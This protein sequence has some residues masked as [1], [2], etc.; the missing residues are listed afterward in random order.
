MLV[1]LIEL[2]TKPNQSTE[3][4]RLFENWALPIARR[5]PGYREGMCLTL[6]PE[7]R[8]LM[9]FTSWHSDQ[10]ADRYFE[11]VYPVIATMLQ[12]LVDRIGTRQFE[13]GAVVTGTC[14]L[15]PAAE[16][17]AMSTRQRAHELTLSPI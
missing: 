6:R 5:Y 4:C 15:Q 2:V 12:P 3:I 9:V 1:R 8:I 13:I 7:P 14:E 17:E 16:I 10:D 11:R